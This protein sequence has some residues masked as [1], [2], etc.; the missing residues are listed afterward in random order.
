[1]DGDVDFL[2]GALS[3]LV[4]GIMEAGV[5]AQ[6]GAGYAERTRDRIT[7]RN[8]CPTRAWDTPV[9]A[10][11]LHIRKIRVSYSMRCRNR[12]GAVSAPC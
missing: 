1:M 5:S 10:K 6:A 11:D 9:R 4:D 7:Q 2:I 12:A 8:N 3:A